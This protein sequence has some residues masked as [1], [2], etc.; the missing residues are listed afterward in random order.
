MQDKAVLLQKIQKDIQEYCDTFFDFTFKKDKPAVHL[1]EPTTSA[2]E[3][4]AAVETMLSSAPLKINT[5][6]TTAPNM[7]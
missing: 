7:A 5:P 6:R 2:D 4:F 3:I 1:H